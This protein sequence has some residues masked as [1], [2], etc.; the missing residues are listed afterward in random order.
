MRLYIDGMMY[1]FQSLEE[2]V[3]YLVKEKF[4]MVLD[5]ADWLNDPDFLNDGMIVVTPFSPLK[6]RAKALLCQKDNLAAILTYA[7][8]VSE[9]IIE[10][11]G[12]EIFLCACD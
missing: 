10:I 7:I 11:S 5:H 2:I 4:I 12:E 6:T 1:M 3:D 8:M 9:Q